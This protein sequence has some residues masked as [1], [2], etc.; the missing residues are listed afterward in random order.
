MTHLKAPPWLFSPPKSYVIISL[1]SQELKVTSFVHKMAS[2]F[3]QDQ[4]QF[5]NIP[6]RG[7]A[8][9]KLGTSF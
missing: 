9:R 5:F 4:Y 1:L 2:E 3:A 7:S 6:Q 8:Q